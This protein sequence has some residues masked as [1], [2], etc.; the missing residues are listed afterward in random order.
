MCR[1]DSTIVLAGTGTSDLSWTLLSPGSGNPALSVLG[2]VSGVV[3]LI[4]SKGGG[5]HLSKFEPPNPAGHC[6]RV[7]GATE[8]VI[9][10]FII[11]V[12]LTMGPPTGQSCCHL[13]CSLHA[14]AD[15]CNGTLCYNLPGHLICSWRICTPGHP[16]WVVACRSGGGGVSKG[17]LSVWV[18]PRGAGQDVAM[19]ARNTQGVLSHC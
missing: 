12:V 13:L 16:W 5:R 3:V 1:A 9:A 19:V 6:G 17:L 2:S 8:G 18:L 10:S 14:A 15:C 4:R 11:H 7:V